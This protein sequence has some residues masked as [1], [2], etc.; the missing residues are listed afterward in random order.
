M[1]NPNSNPFAAGG[2]N[3]MPASNPFGGAAGAGPSASTNN[4]NNFDMGMQ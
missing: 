2:G 3:Q 1:A 4:M